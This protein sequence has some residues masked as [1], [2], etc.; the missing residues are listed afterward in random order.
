MKKNEIASNINV[1][2]SRILVVSAK[3]SLWRWFLRYKVRIINKFSIVIIIK[4]TSVISK[5]K[6]ESNTNDSKLYSELEVH[7]TCPFWMF[8]LLRIGLYDTSIPPTTNI[9]IK[10]FLDFPLNDLRG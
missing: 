3:R 2:S 5:A 6:I 8:S 7:V 4:G 9:P 10:I 1:N